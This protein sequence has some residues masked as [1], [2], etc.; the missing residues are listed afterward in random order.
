M[1]RTLLRVLFLTGISACGAA[2]WAG[3]E[4][5]QNTFDQ[6]VMT[7]GATQ[8]AA[9]ACGATAPDLAQQRETAHR[10]LE[11]FSKEFGF[12]FAGYD[13]TFTAGEQRGQQMMATM[14]RTGADGCTGVM[15]SL[16]HERDMSY[17]DMKAATAEVT[18][19]LPDA[20]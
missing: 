10:N 8:G 13:K 2:A 11:R 9:D 16:Q 20:K 6:L 4:V 12:S 14:K 19:G 17:E 3:S 1:L 18:D 7:A 5:D 15:Q